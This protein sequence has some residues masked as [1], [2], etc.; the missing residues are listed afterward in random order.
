[1]CVFEGTAADCRTMLGGCMDST[2]HSAAEKAAAL[3]CFDG[4][5]GDKLLDD[6]A[7]FAQQY[8]IHFVPCVY[9]QDGSATPV[10]PM[11]TCTNGNVPLSYDKVKKAMCDAGSKLQSGR[12]QVGRRLVD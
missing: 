6:A 11:G 10:D 4:S 12:V 9:V 7:A 3:Q 1:M 8:T 5:A 2:G